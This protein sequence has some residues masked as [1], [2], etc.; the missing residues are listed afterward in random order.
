MAQLLSMQ[1][2]NST[3]ITFKGH[4]RSLETSRFDGVH[5]ISYYRSIVIMAYLVSYLR[6]SH[7]LIENRKVFIPHLYSTPTVGFDL[8]GISPKNV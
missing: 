3:G 5:M 4:S 8:V 7:I 2:I 6:Y 1:S